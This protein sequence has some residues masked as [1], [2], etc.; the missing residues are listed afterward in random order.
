VD[1]TKIAIP[2][3]GDA[4]LQARVSPHFGRCDS[5]AIVTLEGG[6]I[7]STESMPNG[8]H[9]DCASPVRALAENGVNL[10]LVGGMGMRPYL[11][12]Q[13]LGIEIRCGVK[14][15]TVSEAI[16]SYLRGETYAM[17]QDRLCGQHAGETG[18]CHH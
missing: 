10:M 13:Q 11:V 7:S 2:C 5:Y 6:K 8:G 4:D 12:F 15:G 16:Q 1:R 9:T 18:S 17:T 3:V 14:E